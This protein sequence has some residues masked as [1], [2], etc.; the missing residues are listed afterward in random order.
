MVSSLLGSFVFISSEEAGDDGSHFGEGEGIVRAESRFH[1]FS[2]GVVAHETE[3]AGL[4]DVGLEFRVGLVEVGEVGAVG[5]GTTRVEYWLL[6]STRVDCRV[7]RRDEGGYHFRHFGSRDE[8]VRA[9][10]FVGLGGSEVMF[11]SPEE[12]LRIIFR[13]FRRIVVRGF[14]RIVVGGFRRI[15]VRGFRRIIC[16]G[17]VVIVFIFPFS[18]SGILWHILWDSAVVVVIARTEVTVRAAVFLFGASASTVGR[19]SGRWGSR[20]SGWWRN[21]RSDGGRDLYPSDGSGS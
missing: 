20:W 15:V 4:D 14:R 2:V 18:F 16:W 6:V 8:V 7:V 5:T 19:R 21:G 1:G 11:L 13:G 9:E 17:S 10:G 12:C 3:L